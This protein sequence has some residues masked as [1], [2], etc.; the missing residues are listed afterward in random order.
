MAMP[1]TTPAVTP[2]AHVV[3][4]AFVDQY[5]HILHA[6]PEL[7]HRF[8]QDTS[9]LTRPD[10]NGAMKSVTTMQDIDA[11]IL[12]L[13]YKNYK[14]EIK[15]ADAQE[16]FSGGVMVLVTGC[17]TGEDHMQKK[18]AQSFFLAPQDKGYFVLNDVFRYVEEN[19]S[20]TPQSSPATDNVAVESVVSSNSP[21]QQEPTIQSEPT[22]VEPAMSLDGENFDN[23]VEV[24]DNSQNEEAPVAVEVVVES[25]ADSS[26]NED[27]LVS[28]TATS[29]VQE[30]AP[31]KS[32]ASIVKV[33]KGDW[34]PTAVYVP[35][36]RVKATSRNIEKQQVESEAPARG[37]EASAPNNNYAPATR[38]SHEEG[39]GH[40][41]YISS[42]P[43][44]VSVSEVEEEFKKF[45]SIKPGGV[46]VRSNKHQSYCFGFVEFEELGSMQNA[47]EA[48]PVT[49]G[50]RPAFV[51]QKR[52]QSRGREGLSPNRSGGR[53]ENFRSRGNFGGGGRGFGRNEF[54]NRGEF[55]GRGR[56]LSGY[57]RGYQGGGT[58]GGGRQGGQKPEQYSS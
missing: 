51:E 9:V 39:E 53:N 48:S 25:A 32:Y 58:R 33:M 36:N 37:P 47:L 35:A 40:S 4:S 16:S 13:D 3:G 21:S 17:L 38:D 41:I 31:K 55:S 49:I 8:Y 42:L 11:M 1:T 10:I 7:V 26:Q 15:S 30:D 19:D 23:G 50:G 20:L 27:Q 22:V 52:T 34:R 56:G 45:G 18:F 57:Q 54:R 24:Y 46:Q 43:I 14:A 2:S 44:S 5:Y 12:S 28:E 6:S 29:G